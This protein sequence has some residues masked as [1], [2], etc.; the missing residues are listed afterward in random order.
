[1]K[2]ELN[3]LEMIEVEPSQILRAIKKYK[4]RLEKVILVV[5]K[6]NE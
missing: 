4:K 3:K 5:E 1:M 2:K 6:K